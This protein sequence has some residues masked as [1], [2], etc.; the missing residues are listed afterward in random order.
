MGDLL[1]R[2]GDNLPEMISLGVPVPDGFTITTAACRDF[3]ERES[4]SEELEA[5]IEFV[6]EI[7][8][9]RVGR[10][11][12][13][14][15]N[16]LLVSVL[17]GAEFSMSDIMETVLNVGISRDVAQGLA[18]KSEDPKFAWDLLRRFVEIYLQIVC[19][20]PGRVL[21]E[22][23]ERYL[24]NLG[25]TTSENLSTP[26][27]EALSHEFLTDKTEL[28]LNIA[29]KNSEK[30]EVTERERAL[31]AAVN[32]LHEANP[33]MGLRGVPLG[34]LNLELFT[35]Q[36]R[37]T[38][39]ATAN[40][41]EIDSILLEIGVGMSVPIGSM[42]ENLRATITAAKLADYFDFFSFGT[43]GLTQLTK[44]FSR[45]DVEHSF[46]LSYL[47]L[48]LFPFS[49]FE[50]LDHDG[51][52]LLLHI[53]CDAVKAVKLDLKLGVCGEHGDNK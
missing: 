9:N 48:E 1:G 42:L 13:D 16:P 10:R 50:S 31:L 23:L 46:L 36:V 44:A 4:L 43:N 2:K 28:S 15:E 30:K 27:I 35:M 5:E 24:Q 34:V 33:M 12:G 41:Q 32:R 11:F 3:L 19:G 39:R 26:Q 51:V 21:E 29:K 49:P 25:V 52:G 47:D 45:D 7:L 53:A 22:V 37:A 17:S 40:L 8:E 20:V 18:A 14:L 6:V 38:T